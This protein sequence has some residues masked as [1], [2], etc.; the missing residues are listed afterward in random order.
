MIEDVIDALTDRNIINITDLPQTAQEKMFA[1]KSFRDRRSM[2]A[3]Q[4]FEPSPFN[5]VL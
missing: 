1:R 2:K 3:L 4:L 5:G